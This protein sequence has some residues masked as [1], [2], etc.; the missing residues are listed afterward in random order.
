MSSAPFGNDPA[1]IERYNSFWRRAD[2]PRPLVGFTTRGWFPLEEYAATRAW[3]INT[4]LTPEM[5]V[6][7]AFLDDEERL[8]REGE[9]LEDDIIRGDM[10]AAAAIP[11]LSG[12]LGAGCGSCRGTC[13]ARTDR[14]A[15]KRSRRSGS[16]GRTRGSGS[17]SSSPRPWCAIPAADTR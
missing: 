7:E 16:T 4:Y 12:M 1:K 8:L 3:P 9:V 14:R 6:P 13:S 15:G 2:V 10:P 5:V 11:W 17:T